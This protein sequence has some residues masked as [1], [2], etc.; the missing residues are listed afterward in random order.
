MKVPVMQKLAEAMKDIAPAVEKH[1]F[2]VIGIEDHGNS[3]WDYVSL[4]ILPKP[5]PGSDKA[6]ILRREGISE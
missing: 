6:G 3:S 2:L 4:K 1:G 5:E